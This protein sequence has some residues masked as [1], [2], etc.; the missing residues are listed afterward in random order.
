[1]KRIKNQFVGHE[2][3]IHSL[4]F[5]RDGILLASGSGDWT[6]WLWDMKTWLE[7]FKSAIEDGVTS[8]AFSA[9]R[10]YLAA[11]SHDHLMWVW[12]TENT[13]LVEWLQGHKDSVYFRGILT[14]G[15]RINLW[16]SWQ[17]DEIVGHKCSVGENDCYSSTKNLQNDV[18]QS[19]GFC[20]DS[21]LESWWSMGSVRQQWSRRT[22]L[23]S[24]WWT[25]TIYTS[26]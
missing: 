7:L 3:A 23:E 6:A 16:I 9:D 26:R 8:V 14:L 2:Q 25:T 24:Y 15:I 11:S 17:D 22:A 20:A 5:S 21:Y 19:Q 13:F 12:D 1:M 4:D 18:C 10:K